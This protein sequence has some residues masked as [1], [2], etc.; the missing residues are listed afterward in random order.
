[1]TH[2]SENGKRSASRPSQPGD[3]YT[4]YSITA[5]VGLARGHSSGLTSIMNPAKRIIYAAL[6]HPAHGRV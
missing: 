4:Q 6:I 1:M 3:D 5:T 2:V